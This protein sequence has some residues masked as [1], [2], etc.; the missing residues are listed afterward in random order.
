MRHLRSAA[1]A[2][3]ALLTL[4]GGAVFAPP[5]AGAS[6]PFP[7][8]GWQQHN[9]DYDGNGFDDVL[10]GAPGATVSG[11]AG[12]GYVTVQYSSSSGLSTT[13]K[14]VLHQNT[15]GVPGGAEAGD[16]FGQAVAS[17]DLDN[18]GY[19][20]AI[21]GIPGEDLA[22]LSDAGGAV[23]FWGSPTGLHG[24]DST[25]LENPDQL[26]AGANF[27]RAIEAA[28][29]FA[30]DPAHPDANLRDSVAVL[31]NDTLLFF[32][33][34]PGVATQQLKLADKGVRALDVAPLGTGLA[35]RSLSHGNYN[36]DSWADLAI[37]GVTTGDQPGIGATQVL[38]G[39]PSVEA[40]TDGGAFEGGPAVVSS[41]FNHDGQDDLAIGDT[42]VGSPVGG[43]VSVYLGQGD[44]SGLDPT[45]AQTWTQD[46]P[47]VP[48]TAEAG[49][50]WGAEMSS[51]DTN[52][53]GMPDLAVG[54]P[55]EDIGS[56][57]DAGAVWTLRGA[58]GGLTATGARSFDQ[59][60]SDIPGVAEASDAWG[61]QVRLVDANADGLFGLLA[62]APGENTGDGFVWVVPASS[63][64]LVA[65]GTWTYD[66]ARLGAP[67][68]DARFG[69][70]IDE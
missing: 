29:Y 10:I 60:H 59:N 7:S 58:P 14:S 65:K 42:G 22:G 69:A 17:G 32:T 64:G 54:A 15:S 68:A 45:P 11:A 46:S 63:S 9:C 40:L 34:P 50:R 66:G 41:D 3:A 57:S 56:V 30:P 70:A 31:E 44:L 47:G 4:G 16:G 12:A 5:A 18:D 28:R 55:G 38:H 61:G 67:V 51:G 21:V 35:L 19:D 20:D 24:A 39:A 1:L 25:W 2:A 23:V 8:I 33:S 52:G 27:G 43:A 6:V 48:G 49:D 37:S 26:R 13:K 53:D 36:E 62:A